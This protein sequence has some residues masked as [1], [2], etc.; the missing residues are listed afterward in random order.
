MGADLHVPARRV[1]SRLRAEVSARNRMR[2]QTDSLSHEQTYSSQP[3]V[4]YAEENGGHGNFFPPSWRRIQANAAWAARLDKTYTASARVPRS[5]DRWRGELE[6]AT[7]SD[8]LLM[9]IFCH[10]ATMKSATLCAL[11]GVSASDKPEFGWRARVALTNG[12]DDRTEIDMRLGDLLVEAKLCE[13]DFQSAPMSMMWRYDAFADIFDIERLHP[14]RG[15]LRSYQLLRGV[16]AAVEHDARFCLMCD[17]RRSDLKDDWAEMVAAVRYSTVRCRLQ[18]VTWQE[19]AQHLPRPL[20][21]FLDE[22]YGIV[23]A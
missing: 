15:K 22:K 5:R 11:L 8:A 4:V 2:A 13:G 18:I 6:C 1:A 19:I 16:M 10:P 3:A 9:N 7:S 14:R 20:A 23:S 17:A 12:H 21:A